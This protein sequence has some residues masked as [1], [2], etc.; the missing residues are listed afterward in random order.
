MKPE[1]QRTLNLAI[2]ISK[3]ERDR[4]RAAARESGQTEAHAVRAAVNEW[5]EREGFD[6]IFRED[7]T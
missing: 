2:R 5:A 7:C 1:E 6:P 4:L 3:S